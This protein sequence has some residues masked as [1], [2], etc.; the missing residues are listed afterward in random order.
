MIHLD[1]RTIK[2]RWILP[3]DYDVQNTFTY[4]EDENHI[5]LSKRD[6]NFNLQNAH[7]VIAV[8]LR[9]WAYDMY[10]KFGQFQVV[11]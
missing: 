8:A 6:T 9:W 5:H 2:S 3:Y 11:W 1:L 10:T 4:P 7:N